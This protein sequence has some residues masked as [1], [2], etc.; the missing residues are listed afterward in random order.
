V[1]RLNPAWPEFLEPGNDKSAGGV[2]LGLALVA[3]GIAAVERPGAL[4]DDPFG[5]DPAHVLEQFGAPAEDVSFR[6]AR[7]P[8]DRHQPFAEASDRGNS[9]LTQNTDER[10]VHD[11][12]PGGEQIMR[13]PGGP[14]RI[15]GQNENAA[16]QESRNS[17]ENG[18]QPAHGV[19]GKQV[20]PD[21]PRHHL[22]DRW[23]PATHCFPWTSRFARS[24][25]V[26]LC[27]KSER[28]V[29]S[30]QVASTGR[31]TPKNG[32]PGNHL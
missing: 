14:A 16:W 15:S 22:T 9:V 24:A 13:L 17:A 10:P 4:R 8:V 6:V 31:V 32:R 20:F 12:R 19:H 30:G 23:K 29:T 28:S 3:R 26:R 1:Q 21:R 25:Y 2:A 27:V 11:P 5:A 18:P 7:Q